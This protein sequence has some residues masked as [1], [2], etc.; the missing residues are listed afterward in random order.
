VI[1]YQ[2][3][4][5]KHPFQ[6]NEVFQT[7]LAIKELEYEPLPE[8]ISQSSKNLISILLQKKPD[9]RPDAKSLL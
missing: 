6:K 5:S 4:T 9:T 8:N 1:F 7:L 3:L 2:L